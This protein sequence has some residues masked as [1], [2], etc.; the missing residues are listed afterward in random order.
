MVELSFKIELDALLSL[1]TRIS[2][3]SKIYFLNI[4]SYAKIGVQKMYFY[5]HFEQVS[6][7]W[8]PRVLLGKSCSYL[9]VLSRTITY[10]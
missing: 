7:S 3:H 6:L 9:I 8:E 4:K 1:G 2:G 5:T 10:T